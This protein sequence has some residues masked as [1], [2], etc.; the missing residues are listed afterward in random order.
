MAS[1]T[2]LALS[3]FEKFFTWNPT[4]PYVG[5]LRLICLL[6]TAAKRYVEPDQGTP[7]RGEGGVNDFDVCGFFQ[8]VPGRHVY[9]RRKVSVDFGPSKFGHHPEDEGFTGRRVDVMWRD[10][11]IKLAGARAQK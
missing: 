11:E 4:H 3:N 2:Q 10:I 6:Q 1:P 5:R 9:P 8:T 7:D